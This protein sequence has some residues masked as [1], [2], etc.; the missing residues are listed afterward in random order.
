MLPNYSSIVRISIIIPTLNEAREIIE[1]LQ[2][3][4]PLRT[5]GHEVIIVDGG[6]SDQTVSLAR[7]LVDYILVTQQSRGA[8]MNA[9]AKVAKGKL[10]LFLHADSRLPSDFESAICTGFS[11]SQR[12]WG[13]FNVRLSGPSIW[14]RLIEW[15]MNRR[16]RLTGIATGDQALFMQRGVFETA[17]GFP[18]IPLMEDVELSRRLKR[19][20]W[21][22]CLGLSVVSS[23]R[24]W[25][26]RGIV[27]TILL[28]WALRLAYFS[29]VKPE[30]LVQI[31]YRTKA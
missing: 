9:G 19:F 22:L 7:P 18:E 2:P 8:Q 28:M 14:F 11:I 31:Y 23:S 5:K 15:S 29:G 21:P 27:R 4:Q 25:E 3:L 17:G 16:S 26:K 24:Y 12:K 30:R 1:T 20:S 10:L 13:Y 6:S